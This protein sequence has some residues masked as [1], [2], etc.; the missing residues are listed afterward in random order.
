MSY[1][2]NSYYWN[3]LNSPMV[4]TSPTLPIQGT[5]VQSL[6]RE[7]RSLMLHSEAKKRKLLLFLMQGI[8][9]LRDFVGGNA[10][11]RDPLSLP[12]GMWARSLDSL[13]WG[14]DAWAREIEAEKIFL[15]VSEALKACEGGSAV[16][17]HCRGHPRQRHPVTGS[18]LYFLRVMSPWLFPVFWTWFISFCADS[19]MYVLLL[20]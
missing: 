5:H 3:F 12:S 9:L 6:V 8:H 18:S 10:T 15:A 11:V 20:H 1:I 16:S 14:F 2:S 13:S 4:K 19:V 7:L 17:C